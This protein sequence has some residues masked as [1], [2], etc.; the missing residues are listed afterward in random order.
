MA[1]NGVVYTTGQIAKIV[2]VAPRTV[3]MWFDAGR[4]R[5]YRLPGSHDR[6]IPRESLEKFLLE[7][8]MPTIAEYERAGQSVESNLSP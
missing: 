1:E 4:I 7:H 2:K 3:A 8:G 5:G 6:R